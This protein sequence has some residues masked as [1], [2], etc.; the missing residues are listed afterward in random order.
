MPAIAPRSMPHDSSPGRIVTPDP[1]TLP[2]AG[3]ELRV[4]ARGGMAR[5]ICEQR[6]VN[7]SSEPLSVTYALPLPADAAVSGFAFRVGERRIV[8]EIDRRTSARERF[9]RAIA[10]GRT[11]ALLEEERSS[12]FT[13]EIGNVPPGAEVLAEVTLDQPLI[14]THAGEWEWRFPTTVLPRYLGAP[15]RVADAPAMAQE[16]VD[17]EIPA[18]VRLALAVEDALSNGRPSAPSHALT[19]RTE[20]RTT[21]V[22]LAAEGGAPLDR[23]LCVR[24]PVAGAEADA[25]LETSAAG[26]GPLA[27]AVFGVLSVVPPAATESTLPRDVCV[28]LDTSGSMS[29]RPLD[30]A[31][32]VILGLIDG[33][34]SADTLE[35]VEFS[36]RAR[37]WKNRPVPATDAA[38]A[39]ARAWLD[40]LRAG[41][42][43]EM[44]DAVLAALRPLRDDAQRQVVLVTD[45]A[46]GF[47]REVV[48]A[49]LER[50][51]AG[52]RLHTVG[53]GSAVNRSLTAPAARAGRGVEIVVGLD[54][55]AERA[56]DRLL[57]RTRAP[58]VVE[59]E[60]T[61]N[62]LVRCTPERLPDLFAGAP[63]L[64][65]LELAPGARE[66]TLR[67]VL[68]GGVRWE[69]R[70]AIDPA[71]AGRSIVRSFF[72]RERVAD[73]ETRLAAGE[74][75][76]AIDAE[77]EALGLKFQISTRHTSWVALTE[78]VTVDPSAPSRRVRMPHALPA[79]TSIESLGLRGPMR[80]SA[81]AAPMAM[82][83]PLAAAP[84][85]GTVVMRRR[86]IL[87]V[88]Q[89]APRA[90]LGHV[91]DLL[92]AG[93]SEAPP[94]PRS[95]LGYDSEDLTSST[96]D[97]GR[98]E[99]APIDELLGAVQLKK[100]RSLVI[101]VTI[102]ASAGFQWFTGTRAEVAWDS[103][104]TFDATVVEERSTR[105]GRVTIGQTVRVWLELST[106][107]PS[108]APRE[109]WLVDG[110]RRICIRI[111]A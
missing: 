41:G 110:E 103:G 71:H 10:E 108:G 79:G 60:I 23:D 22:A 7:R 75:A 65:G 25:T 40:G 20:G 67:G 16:I 37:R 6:F 57:R 83:A 56:A 5:V 92:R 46:I 53:I 47:E 85:R 27:G 102:D 78:D 24:W 94:P 26:D 49:I 104:K 43:T 63:V 111:V 96:A 54:D 91:T 14:W 69:R 97:E 66:V 13:Q 98:F 3:V 44:A 86:S 109:V 77:I 93:S 58:A 72:G 34:R 100:G 11:A 28:L 81:A 19:C 87:G 29:G 18:R 95:T 70:V 51:P 21:V 107:L 38:R 76:K 30:Q 1:S 101:A 64:V 12:L 33:L 48:A 50:L 8:G 36:D 35:L 74:A 59:L 82:V 2:L 88:A 39:E 73:L 89:E 42:S 55:D 105:A 90:I 106:D 15:G 80:V 99:A 17:G 62:D 31:R 52:C 61:G 32:R 9:E 84:A 4:E 68:A 45:G